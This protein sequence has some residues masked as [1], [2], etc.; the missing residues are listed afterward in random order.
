LNE[1]KLDGWNIEGGFS[2]R[3]E[4]GGKV[5]KFWVRWMERIEI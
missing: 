5:R 4:N 3:M 1:I 2:L